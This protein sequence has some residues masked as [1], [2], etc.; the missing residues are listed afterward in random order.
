MVTLNNEPS[1]SK[2]K[3]QHDLITLNKVSHR[4]KNQNQ[5]TKTKELSISPGFFVSYISK[6][7]NE[8]NR[9]FET[10]IK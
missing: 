3:C 5:A 10:V 9:P 1:S 8:K 4:K 6:T 2:W 7:N